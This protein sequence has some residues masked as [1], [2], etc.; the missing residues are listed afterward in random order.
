MKVGK[1]GAASKGGQEGAANRA[2]GNPGNW[3]QGS[4]ERKMLQ[5][6]RKEGSPMPSSTECPV[7]WGY[8][9]I[10]QLWD[11]EFGIRKNNTSWAM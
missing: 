8:N 6:G 2:E 4:Q 7:N 3:D 5:E 10:Q 9:G 1:G 11:F